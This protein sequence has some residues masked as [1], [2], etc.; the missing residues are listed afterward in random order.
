VIQIRTAVRLIFQEDAQVQLSG[1][2]QTSLSDLQHGAELYD[3][4][5]CRVQ[6]LTGQGVKSHIYTLAT[7]L[8]HDAINESCVYGIED[9]VPRHVE[10]LHQVLDLI[11][12][13]NSDEDVG[14][15]HLGQLNGSNAHTTTSTVDQDRLEQS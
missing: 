8:G 13:T 11:L 15:G 6:K 1:S 9:S 14:A 3:K 10:C 4:A 5:P 2:K 12:V 7:S